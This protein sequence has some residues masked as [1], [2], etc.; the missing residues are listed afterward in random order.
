MPAPSFN[1]VLASSSPFRQQLLEKLGLPF[2]S[3]SPEIDESRKENE[4]AEA[5]V[6]RLAF[7]KAQAVAQSH[8]NSLIIGSDQ[9]AINANGEILGKPGTEEKAIA[10]LQKASGTKVIFAT[11]LCLLNSATGKSQTACEKFS[12]QFR[13]LSEQTIKRY[14][15][16]EKPLSSA[17]SFKSEGMGIVLFHALE[18]RDPNALVGLPLILLTDFLANEGIVLPLDK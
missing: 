6:Q 18:G 17:G 14:V 7:E 9:V 4:S 5:L 3:H 16:Q 13:E 1:L 11:G 12:V 10:Q 2:T 8:P 15:T